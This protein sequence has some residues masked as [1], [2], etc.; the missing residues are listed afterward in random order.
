MQAHI[1]LVSVI[2]LLAFPG[3][4]VSAGA[5]HTSSR[6]VCEQHGS[7]GQRRRKRECN[8][9]DSWPEASGS[10]SK[11]QTVWELSHHLDSYFTQ[12]QTFWCKHPAMINSA[13]MNERWKRHVSFNAPDRID[14]FVLPQN[15]VW[16]LT[17]QVPPVR[18]K[19]ENFYIYRAVE[20]SALQSRWWQSHW[21]KACSLDEYT[22]LKPLT[23]L[24]NGMH[25]WRTALHIICYLQWPK[26]LVCC[27]VNRLK[28]FNQ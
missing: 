15:Q 11:R 27:E 19:E 20:P 22:E 17:C 23:F 24:T 25:Q 5:F 3:V 9:P 21:E 12:K 4:A 13:D 18:V 2:L 26:I 28:Y 10:H 14:I 8:Q 6:S 16:S 7:D 1:F